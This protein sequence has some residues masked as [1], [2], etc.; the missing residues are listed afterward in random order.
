ME[1]IKFLDDSD[2][3]SMFDDN[4][5]SNEPKIGGE[6]LKSA[7]NNNETS[8]EVNANEQQTNNAETTNDSK[9]IDYQEIANQLGLEGEVTDIESLRELVNNT[10]TNGL[11][12]DTRR[13]KEALESGADSNDV[14]E[15]EETLKYLHSITKDT[16]LEES[17]EAD[18]TRRKLILQDFINQGIDEKEAVE[19]VKKIFKEG[20]DIEEAE[21]ALDENKKFFRQE[22]QRLIDEAK[23]Q[24]DEYKGKIDKQTADLK[25]MIYNSNFM[26][27]DV[28]EK[29]KKLALK[30]ISEPIY[31]DKETGD[32]LTALQKYQRENPTAFLHNLTM[33]Y[34]LTNG[35]KSLDNIVNPI[36]K[37]RMNKQI[38]DVEDVLR[39]PSISDGSL[40]MVTPSSSKHSDSR[41]KFGI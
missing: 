35:F 30:N 11:D 32:M 33:L 21:R 36:V 7:F 5:E 29:T 15:F 6:E 8:E 38:N 10:I 39:N 19:R 4:E 22:Y 9:S 26:S 17:E 16:L 24:Q 18:N 31:R 37:K 23:N 40:K 13:V 27:I 25:D 12:E 1:G 28:D 2:I 3:K 34:T 41:F 14:Y 20:K